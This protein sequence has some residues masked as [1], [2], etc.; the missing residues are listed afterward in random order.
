MA[1]D[2]FEVSICC[3][4]TFNIFLFLLSFIL[5][6]YRIY[7]LY[8]DVIEM[9]ERTLHEKEVAAICKGALEG[10]VRREELKEEGDEWTLVVGSWY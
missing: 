10:I 4:V 5:E 3:F 9:S 8:T 2:L 7:T 1:W 6:M